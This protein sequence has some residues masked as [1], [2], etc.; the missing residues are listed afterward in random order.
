QELSN[1]T[2]GYYGERNVDYMLRTYP[3]NS[4]LALPDIRLNHK[5]FDFQLDNIILTHHCFVIL[6]TKNWAGELIYE[7][8]LRQF[9]KQK[10]D[11]KKRSPCPIAHAEKQNQNLSSW[12]SEH[13]LP[14]PPI[15]TLT[16]IS[17]SSNILTI[18]QQD[19]HFSKKF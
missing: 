8:K 5:G 10:N 2:A 11:R 12:I 7:P 1:R 14:D 6:E 9:I 17:N 3:N 4:A 18:P 19:E 13:G 15:E 16:V